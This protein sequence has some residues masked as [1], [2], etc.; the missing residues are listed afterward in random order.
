MKASTFLTSFVIISA[1][2]SGCATRG[3]NHAD[4][5]ATSMQR[6]AERAETGAAQIETAL[7]ALSD[8]VENPGSDLKVQFGK[9]NGAVSNI[10]SLGKDIA[11][12]SASMK[13]AGADYF[14]KWD[15]ELA[16]IQ[17]EDIRSR[18]A[19]RKT[20]VVQSFERVQ[21]SYQA[22]SAALTP[23]ITRLT[24]IRT[25]IST[26]LTRAGLDSIRSSV[27]GVKSEGSSVQQ[28]LKTLAADFKRLGT[29][30]SSSLPQPAQ[31][32]TAPQKTTT[33]TP[34]TGS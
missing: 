22:A 21:S 18:S 14:K 30:I 6:G 8:L 15:E 1:L 19:A 34:A 25:A 23:L 20:E 28:L 33:P 10:E 11:G 3:Y 17:S 2:V 13:Q 7:V 27:S 12:K 4:S 31:P 5:A 29:S 16:R 26:D 24:D 32:K 9:F